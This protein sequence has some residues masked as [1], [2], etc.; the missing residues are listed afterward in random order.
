MT[1]SFQASNSS[2]RRGQMVS[3]DCRNYQSNPAINSSTDGKQ[4]ST[5]ATSIMP[6]GEARS[7]MVCTGP[8]TSWP[9]TR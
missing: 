1:D 2:A 7:T 5:G 6:T 9:M 4:P 3:P 8:F